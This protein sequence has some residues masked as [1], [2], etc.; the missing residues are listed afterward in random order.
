MNRE[1]FFKCP[2]EV[3]LCDGTEHVKWV[4]KGRTVDVYP[5]TSLQAQG[6]GEGPQLVLWAVDAA[7]IMHAS[8]VPV[9]CHP[10]ALVMIG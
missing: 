8:P 6:W 7:K 1:Y 9:Y 5:C 3:C 10:D 4:F 2:Q